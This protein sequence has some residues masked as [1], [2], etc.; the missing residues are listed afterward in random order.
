MNIV[1]Q[2]VIA[3][4]LLF[5]LLFIFY[6]VL[7][8]GFFCWD[9]NVYVLS[10]PYLCKVSF[11][12]L[13]N[14][15]LHPYNGNY[16]PLTLLSYTF[17]N[18][19]GGQKPFIYH[20]HNLWLHLINTLLV[21]V[22]IRK[23]TGN[24]LVSLIVALLF[25]IT[26]LHIESVIWVSERKDLLYTLYFLLAFLSYLKYSSDNK[27][28]YFILTVLFFLMSLLSK[29]QAVVFP[30]CLIAY[31]IIFIKTKTF[32]RV[33]TEKLPLLATSVFFGAITII[34]QYNEGYINLNLGYSL[35]D[36]FFISC[37]NLVLYFSKLA[38][39]NN[40]SVF[41]PFPDKT[42]ERLPL[43]YYIHALI[44][45][46]F[47][48]IIIIKRKKVK[49]NVLFGIT[50]FLICMLLFVQ[51][52][53]FG[54]AKMADRYTYLSSVG[55]FIIIV[56]GFDKIIKIHRIFYFLLFLY[57]GFTLFQSLTRIGLWQNNISLFEDAKEKYPQN[58]IILNNLATEQNKNGDIQKALENLSEAISIDSDYADAYYN[59]GVI[60][61]KNNNNEQ[62]ISD[63]SMVIKLNPKYEKAFYN[64]GNVYLR[65]ENFKEAIHDFDRSI[66]LFNHNA[67]A[68]NNRG[69]AR[70][71]INNVS[72]A[73]SDFT[74]AIYINPKHYLAY[75][76]RGLGFGRFKNFEKAI[77]D[78]DNCI[79]INPA[80]SKVYYYRGIAKFETGN[81]GCD[82][83]MKAANS[84]FQPALDAF[85]L[86]CQ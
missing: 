80:Y 41:Y 3:F 44:F 66:M 62:A 4:L 12:S 59:R 27:K 65:Q 42:T 78:F 31:D 38:F 67:D 18:L 23:I 43:I 86:Y 35:I 7:F 32:K 47:L 5:L 73:I 75:F 30:L 53:P 79:I 25:E 54:E 13:K 70:L 82:D 85:S 58:E 57:C 68:Y 11:G 48:I 74:L 52:I 10:N 40:L 22:L 2:Y 15:F 81:F 28:I 71:S 19:I 56:S 72:G 36:R 29:G 26:P 61:S 84:G 14:I 50:F 1:K 20:A 6:R 8:Y 46:V 34:T 83:L 16:N 77:L 24:F 21:F 33:V 17:D 76:N 39:P 64:R 45:I 69:L 37:S 51:F 9:D 49:S 63:Y 60:Y 55:I